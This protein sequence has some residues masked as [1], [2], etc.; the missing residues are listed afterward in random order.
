MTSIRAL[1][2]A[3]AL[4]AAPIAALAQ[5]APPPVTA[6]D[7]VLGRSDAPVTVIE[8]ASF[9]CPHCAAWHTSVYPEF[10]RRFIDTGQARLVFRDLPTAPAETSSYAAVLARCAA[11][12]RA[13]DVIHALMSGQ[14]EGLATRNSGP[15]F[16]S[17]VVVS[18]RTTAEVLDCIS[19]PETTTAL[20]ASIVGA[21]AAGVDGTPTFFVNGRMVED[22]SLEGLAAAIRPLVPPSASGR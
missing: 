9:T 3:I 2:L 4:M 11:P 13:F 5:S 6:S 19:D 15:W 1:L 16:N 17:A 18:G 22:S 14:A 20:R 21:N 12:D 10:K 8:Y 7:R